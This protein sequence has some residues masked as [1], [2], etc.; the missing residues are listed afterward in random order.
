MP[1]HEIVPMYFRMGP[2][3]RRLWRRRMA[4][5]ETL[6]LVCRGAAGISIDEWSAMKDDAGP[7]FHEALTGRPLYMFAP[8]PW[9][10]EML[11]DLPLIHEAP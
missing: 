1:V 8:R 2:T 7:N 4:A 5:P 9:R 3:E 10:P 6:P 11:H